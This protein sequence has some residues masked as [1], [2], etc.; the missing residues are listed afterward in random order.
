MHLGNQGTAFL[1][2][3]GIF[4]A[5]AYPVYASLEVD[6]DGAAQGDLHFACEPKHPAP[7]SIGVEFDLH[8]PH[9]ESIVADNVI[10]K[11]RLVNDSGSITGYV[12]GSLAQFRPKGKATGSTEENSEKDDLLPVL[13]RKLF[14]RDLDTLI[15]TATEAEP[16]SL[17]MLDLDH[18]KSVNDTHGHPVGD[19]VL[20]ECA[21]A[22]VR[23][24]RR[25]GK[26][27]RVGGEEIAVLLPNFTLSEAVALA[28]SI[29]F[30][31]EITKMSG[32][33]LSITASIGVATAPIH[34]TEGKQL[35]TVAD[36]ALYAA[37]RLGRN[38]VRIAADG[39]VTPSGDASGQVAEKGSPPDLKG[40]KDT[41][42]S[43]QPG[44]EN[45][46]VS[47]VDKSNTES[48]VGKRNK[49]L[50][51]WLGLFALAV[52]VALYLLPKTELVIIGCCLLIWGSLIHPFINFWWVEDRRLRQF[53]AAMIL[54]VGAVLLGLYIKP[55]KPHESEPEKKVE[56][57][58][59][60]PPP[61]N[62]EPSRPDA[63]PKHGESPPSTP[64]KTDS[65]AARL[66]AP[67]GFVSFVGQVI[68]G[69]AP[70]MQENQTP[71]PL[72]DVHL[73]IVESVPKSA[74]PNT[75]NEW[76]SGTVVWQKQLEIGTCRAKL[77]TDLPE[78]FPVEGQKRLFFY[79]FMMTRFQSYRETIRLT[80]TSEQEYSA[81]LSF[82][83]G[84]AKP[85]YTR[86]MKLQIATL[87]FE[88]SSNPS[89]KAKPNDQK[90]LQ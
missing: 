44:P 53:L 30:E 82:Y 4:P 75:A 88:R 59:T 36:K 49:P 54:T 2:D 42:E 51:R 5:G 84:G 47:E 22:I 7:I 77:T 38:L 50:D 46:P 14:Q 85:M 60:V 34:A 6:G 37:K 45:P 25:K 52:G 67:A 33:K 81:E 12:I 69:Y 56:E 32:K 1:P 64:S 71:N 10:L 70:M 11:V 73:S 23:R 78:R 43:D 87:D 74:E 79:I 8:V 90:P 15:G 55:E 13:R 35:F 58:R 17:L 62:G 80:R 3:G 9:P 76:G 18:F 41:K 63:E 83:G 48:I 28:E 21:N 26:V 72:D 68:D 65:Q 19:E 89:D 40:R 57:I 24:C 61:V 16:V 86:N 66:L 39:P 27:Y 20:I 31:I 29:R